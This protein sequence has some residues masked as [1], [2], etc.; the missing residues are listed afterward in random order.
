MESFFFLEKLVS[1]AHKI[2][3]I[4]GQ[5]SNSYKYVYIYFVNILAYNFYEY[6]V[7]HSL[8]HDA[9]LLF[10]LSTSIGC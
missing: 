4:A 8:M 1:Y 5:I 7:V 9:A 6:N 3:H 10:A 2:I